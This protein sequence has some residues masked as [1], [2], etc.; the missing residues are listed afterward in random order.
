MAP[1][2]LAAA[3]NGVSYNGMSGSTGGDIGRAI[4]DM[5]T[6]GDAAR[7]E[8]TKNALDQSLLAVRQGEADVNAKTLSHNISNDE[9][10]FGLKQLTHQDS[11]AQHGD[12]AAALEAERLRQDAD[13]DARLTE[14]GRFHS[15]VA[16]LSERRLTDREGQQ[17][18]VQ[19]AQGNWWGWNPIKNEAEQY[20]Q[21]PRDGKM[22]PKG[23][24]STTLNRPLGHAAAATPAS[25]A[26]QGGEVTPTG[27]PEKVVQPGAKETPAQ[28]H[29]ATTATP[30]AKPFQG[31]NAIPSNPERV[32]EGTLQA[33]QGQLAI[34]GKA[35]K[36]VHNKAPSMLTQLGLDAAKTPQSHIPGVNL[37]TSGIR[38]VGNAYVG[39]ADPKYQLVQNGLNAVGAQFVKLM[40]GLASSDTEAQRLFNT[41]GM[42]S[43]DEPDAV[44]Q[45]LDQLE[46]I[47]RSYAVQAGRAAPKGVFTHALDGATQESVDYYKS[48]LKAGK[49][50]EQAEQETDAKFG[51]TQ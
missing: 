33:M 36:S 20:F 30:D 10:D 34:Y 3:L 8:K 11:V 50:P 25:P 42:T 44:K 40:S 6:Q 14:S 39:M 17:R 28:A 26:T 2:P 23:N 49:T 48:L 35:L 12:A 7:K 29:A 1:K 19:D 45:K 16:G 41:V 43:G 5:I 4:Q 31:S 32:A 15:L 51:G 38:S 21:D 37:L 24:L 22:K 47:Y 9:R 46:N 18:P 13:R 27:E